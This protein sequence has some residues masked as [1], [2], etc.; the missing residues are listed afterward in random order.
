MR[1]K[2]ANEG[3]DRPSTELRRIRFK[4]GDLRAISRFS[5]QGGIPPGRPSIESQT[6]IR[7]KNRDFR[8]THLCTR[9]LVSYSNSIRTRRYETC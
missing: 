3:K 7:L 2:D 5:G 4:F 6:N 8:Q 1:G 9:A